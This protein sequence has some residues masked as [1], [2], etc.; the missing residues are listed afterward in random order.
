[1]NDLPD[2]LKSA[3]PLP[4][5]PDVEALWDRGRRAARRRTQGVALGGLAVALLLTVTVVRLTDSED[6]S[7]L[8]TVG[9]PDDPPADAVTEE[10]PAPPSE[11]F[12]DGPIGSFVHLYPV[13]LPDDWTVTIFPQLSRF[14]FA[15]RRLRQ[16]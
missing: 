3:V 13:G 14:R 8:N 4:A 11:V 10:P 12:I 2:R 15:K 1:M 16:S 9:T 7:P 5:T 6:A